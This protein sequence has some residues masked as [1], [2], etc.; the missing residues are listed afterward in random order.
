MSN[1]LI[2]ED[3]PDLAFGLVNNLEIDGH[4]VEL[5]ENGALGLERAKETRPDLVIL[6]LMLPGLN[7]Y[8]VLKGLRDA[9]MQTPVLILSARGEEA[10]KVRGFRYGADDYVTKPFSLLEMLARV[11]AILRRSR[12]APPAAS[13]QERASAY[14]FG[15]VEVDTATRIVRR[16]GAEV[17]LSPKA[18]ELL[19]TL[20][21]LDGKVASRH[22]LLR[23]VW[24]Y[25]AAVMSRTVDTHIAEL[26]R[27][28]ES[29]P[30]NPRHILTIFKAGYRLQV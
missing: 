7:G 8:G 12:S 23:K 3:N 29:D 15:D 9:G 6:D 19:L 25:R 11:E 5:V 10:D 28:L 21:E 30:A 26:R 14:H 2:I 22:D 20:I 24:G 17:Q 13:A 18:Y 4:H 16:H 27:K 1:V